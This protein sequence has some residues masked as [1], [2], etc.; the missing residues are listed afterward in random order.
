MDKLSETFRATVAVFHGIIATWLFIDFSERRIDEFNFLIL[1]VFFTVTNIII[2]HAI[3]RLGRSLGLLRRRVDEGLAIE[4]TT[5]RTP[6][7]LGLTLVAIAVGLATAYLDRT[8]VVLRTAGLVADWHRSSSLPPFERMMFNITDNQTRLLD[9]REP[10][11]VKAALAGGAY[12]RVFLK[13]SR[14]AYEGFPGRSSTRGTV[15]EREAVLTPAC[16]VT[17]DD[18]EPTKIASIQPIEGLGVFVRGDAIAIEIIDAYQSPCANL[19]QKAAGEKQA[20]GEQG[21]PHRQ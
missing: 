19:L 2:W 20:R 9:K 6:D 18:K 12:L 10:E 14:V 1:L 4:K 15:E 8:D 16:R 11:F 21:S 7:V 5:F 17:F 3:L 13:D